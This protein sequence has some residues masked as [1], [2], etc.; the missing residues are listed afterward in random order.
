MISNTLKKGLSLFK[1]NPITE[2]IDFASKKTIPIRHL[3]IGFEGK[4]VDLS[5]YMNNQFATI[6]FATL[7]VFLTYGEDLVIETARHHRDQLKDPILKQRVTSLIGQEAIHSKLHNEFNDAIVELDYPVKLYRFLGEQFFEHIF[8]KFPQPLKLS[9]MAGIEHFTAVLAEY[10]MAHEQ[11]FYF[12]DD[13]KTRALW[14]WH[15]LEESEHKDVAYD[16][17]QTL[18]GNYA[19]RISG[20]LLAYFTILG[21]IPFSATMV[22]ILRK[23]QEMLTS[24]FWKDARRGV[25]LIFSPKDG[26]F[27]S[28]QGRIFDYLRTDFH[29]NDHDASA[30]FE[31][32]EKKLLSE[33]GAL[34][35]FFVKEFTPKVQAA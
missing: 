12:S 3:A 7:S 14:M 21:L 27:G 8:L 2:Q 26:V 5:F 1:S 34:Y 25:K 13:A 28:T 9:L 23:P 29:P 30:Y 22:P 19:L 4:Q 17:Y 35:P 16:V 32:Y 10:M 6:F 20:F 31:Y 11:N 15:M 18:N 24:K 33:G